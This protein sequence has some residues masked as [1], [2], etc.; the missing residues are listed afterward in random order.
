MFFRALTIYKTSDEFP[1]LSPLNEA[2][3]TAPFEPCTPSQIESFGWVPV[4]GNPGEYVVHA[5]GH[6]LLSLCHERKTVPAATIKRIANDRAAEIEKAEGYKPGRKQIR[7][8][9]ETVATELVAKAIPVQSITYIWINLDH[10]WFGINVP[11]AGKVDIVIEQLKRALDKTPL[12]SIHTV[13]SP[14]AMMTGWLCSGGEDRDTFTIDRD[15]E[16]RSMGEDKSAVKWTRQDL[17]YKEIYHHIEAGKRAT[18]LALTWDSKISFI[19]TED[20]KIKRIAFLDILQ[21]KAD[22]QAED[23]ADILEADLTIMGGEL[24]L[25]LN[26][27]VAELGGYA[28]DLLSKLK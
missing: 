11:S 5:D 14:S 13:Q 3:A 9:R 20:L 1:A 28:E 22:Q 15:C 10:G 2:L 19:L 6:Y 12:E 23:G 27:L 17:N 26:D 8:I 7:E 16:L 21:E 24:N 4:R 25:M 18:Q